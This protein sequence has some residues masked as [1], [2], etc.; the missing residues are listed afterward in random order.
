MPAV[1]VRANRFAAPCRECRHQVAEGQGVLTSEAGRWVTRHQ[2]GSCPLAPAPAPAARRPQVETSVPGGFYA[3]AALAGVN[4]LDFYAVDRPTEGR[5]EGYVFVKHVVGGRPG[6]AVRGAEAQAVLARV[7]AVGHVAAAMRFGQHFGRCGRCRRSL[8]DAVSRAVGLGPDCRSMEG[9]TVTAEQ[10]RAIY[11][12]ARQAAA[13]LVAPAAATSA[14]CRHCDGVHV[15]RLCPAQDP[16]GYVRAVQ[17][18][19]AQAV[20]QEEAA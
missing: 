17:A 16:V 15:G 3:V 10:A 13:K 6:R 12:A 5:W 1:R 8:T 9:W 7:E 4:D 20:S 14:G 18:L 2:P 11:A 19:L